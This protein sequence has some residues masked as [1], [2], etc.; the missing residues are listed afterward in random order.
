MDLY[1][2]YTLNYGKLDIKINNNILYSNNIPIKKDE[3]NI[4]I[5]LKDLSEILTFV[6]NNNRYLIHIINIVYNTEP[7][8]ETNLYDYV[9]YYRTICCDNYGDIYIATTLYYDQKYNLKNKSNISSGYPI[10]AHINAKIAIEYPKK[11]FEYPLPDILISYIRNIQD[12]Y[13]FRSIDYTNS[14]QNIISNIKNISYYILKYKQENISNTKLLYDKNNEI[15]QLIDERI[16]I[17]KTN[18]NVKELE[19]ILHFLENENIA[20]HSLLK[21]LNIK[22]QEYVNIIDNLNKKNQDCIDN[23]IVLDNNVKKLKKEIEKYK[24]NSIVYF[25]FN[26]FDLF[27]RFNEALVDIHRYDEE[28]IINIEKED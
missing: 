4:N 22:N 3:L 28:Y 2:N 20:N 5:L 19:M 10:K 7:S 12:K 1:N 17:N 24:N 23:N 6:E 27:Y 14:I 18:E 8:T 9:N 26:F 25:I 16:N 13:I 15:L 21:E 11:L